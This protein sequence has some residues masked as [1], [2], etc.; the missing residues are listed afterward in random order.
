MSGE[1]TER[2]QY[3]RMYFSAEDGIV[4]SFT[5]PGL[6]EENFSGVVM[7]IS[8]GGMCLSI[9]MENRVAISEGGSLLIRR[10]M[11][12]PKLQSIVDVA[13]SVRW[14]IELEGLKNI[15]V[16]CEFLNLIPDYKELINKFI[17]S[18]EI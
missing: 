3:T 7:D 16:G 6:E 13:A 15:T 12:T 14:I 4:S 17:N 11:G 2:R 8:E 1:F 18:W 10:F 9:A 5:V